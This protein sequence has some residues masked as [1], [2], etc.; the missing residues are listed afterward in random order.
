MATITTTATTLQP[1]H[2]NSTSIWHHRLDPDGSFDDFPGVV[3]SLTSLGSDVDKCT[4]LSVNDVNIVAEIGS[5]LLRV[6]QWPKCCQNMENSA[7]AFKNGGR[8]TDRSAISNLDITLLGLQAALRVCFIWPAVHQ[9]TL[10]IIKEFAYQTMSA[11]CS[12]YVTQYLPSPEAVG[13]TISILLKGGDNKSW[14]E[15]VDKAL[16]LLL[17]GAHSRPFRSLLL[18]CSTSSNRIVK[19]LLMMGK[20]HATLRLFE[21]P[22]DF[23]VIEG[24]VD[25]TPWVSLAEGCCSV[26]ALPE[27]SRQTW[28]CIC[29]TITAVMAANENVDDQ[30]KRFVVLVAAGGL[31]GAPMKCR[32]SI[33]IPIA[34]IVSRIKKL[35][36]LKFDDE[37]KS[38][39]LRGAED[40][41]IHENAADAIALSLAA[42]QFA[43]HHQHGTVASLY[44]PISLM[45]RDVVIRRLCQLLIYDAVALR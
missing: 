16:N 30:L 23:P 40:D 4:R 32:Y 22:N 28:K 6:L 31:C 33:L 5:R 35:L 38:V 19:E 11:Y 27:L 14:N 44:Y 41:Q 26:S 42:S 36:V 12:G 1:M 45:E 34:M 2:L 10:S 17:N 24:W 18:R 39:A 43:V 9:E 7:V 29:E 15:K 25:Y 13:H 3:A 20:L 21:N 37:K 8:N